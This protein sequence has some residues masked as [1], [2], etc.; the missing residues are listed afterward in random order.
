MI[1]FLKNLILDFCYGKKFEVSKRKIEEYFDVD[2]AFQALGISLHESS[3]PIGPVEVITGNDFRKISKNIPF[4]Y[5]Y[6]KANLKEEHL[7]IPSV[8]FHFF[9]NGGTWNEIE[10]YNAVKNHGMLYGKK[11]RL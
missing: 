6:R 8:V 2:I 4:Y 5:Q 3:L 10:E 1:S 7:I 11:R 9:M